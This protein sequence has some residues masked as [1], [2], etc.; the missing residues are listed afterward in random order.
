MENFIFLCSGTSGR[1]RIWLKSSENKYRE[2][3]ENIN[4]NESLKQKTGIRFAQKL[5]ESWNNRNSG[6]KSPVNL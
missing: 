1:L 2:A 4:K 3:S 6:A 5:L